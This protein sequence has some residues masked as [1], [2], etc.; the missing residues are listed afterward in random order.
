MSANQINISP[1]PHHNLLS[2]AKLKYFKTF[3]YSLIFRL[4]FLRNLCNYTFTLNLLLIHVSFI[5]HV[6]C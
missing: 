6:A 3:E 5:L 4:F 1:S 2:S